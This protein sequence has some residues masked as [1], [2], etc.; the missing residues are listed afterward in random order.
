[1]KEIIITS[2][3]IKQE[4]IA[5]LVCFIVANLLNVYSIYQFNTPWSELYTQW[6]YI[7]LL[8]VVIYAVFTFLR[9]IVCGIRAY[10]KK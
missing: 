4:W 5:L 8:S 10:L 3:H 7:L 1:M 6:L 9:L 2:K